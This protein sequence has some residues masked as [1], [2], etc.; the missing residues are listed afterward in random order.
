MWLVSFTE[1]MPAEPSPWVTASSNYPFQP[2]I[3]GRLMVKFKCEPLPPGEAEM[4]SDLSFKTF[5]NSV[6]STT[7]S[8]EK[9][10]SSIEMLAKGEDFHLSRSEIIQQR[11]ILRL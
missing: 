11:P 7:G 5:Y 6:T 9:Q 1:S 8:K 2:E 3:E 4:T 10:V